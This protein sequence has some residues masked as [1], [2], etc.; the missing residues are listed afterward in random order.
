[1]KILGGGYQRETKKR[2]SGSARRSRGDSPASVREERIGNLNDRPASELNS[3]RVGRAI[4]GEARRNTEEKLQRVADHKKNHRRK[5]AFIAGLALVAL[6]FGYC[7]FNYLSELEAKRAAEAAA[8]ETKKEP[9]APIHDENAGNN[10][11]QR[12]KDFVARLED[13]VVDYELQVERIVLPYRLVR[14]IDVYLVGRAEHYK[15][16]LD[17]DTAVQAEDMSRMV[18]YLDEKGIQCEYVD[19]RIE[20]KA[21]YK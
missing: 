21:Y 8:V 18:R 13:D 2:R 12:V 7:I 20:G 9:K 5:I 4:A 16:N 1:M 10:V 14:E 15:M 3:F 6:I 19:L 17:R 11:S